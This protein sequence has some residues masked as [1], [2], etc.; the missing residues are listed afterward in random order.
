MTNI[1]FQINILLIPPESLNETH[2]CTGKNFYFIL[3]F[4]ARLLGFLELLLQSF[5]GI[6]HLIFLH[7]QIHHH[8]FQTRPVRLI[9]LAYGGQPCCEVMIPEINKSVCITCRGVMRMRLRLHA[10]NISP[11]LDY[12]FKNEVQLIYK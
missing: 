9:G 6:R 8:L 3:K 4:E 12:C 10:L 11:E 1:Y 7:C 2:E 5:D